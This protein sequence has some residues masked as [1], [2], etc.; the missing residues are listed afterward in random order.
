MGQGFKQMSIYRRDGNVINNKAEKT[1]ESAP[2]IS[3]WA[4]V[5]YLMAIVY[6]STVHLCMHSRCGGSIILCPCS[7]RSR[8]RPSG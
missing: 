7:G 1:Q 6:N 3:L 5:L 8:V 2:R 4:H